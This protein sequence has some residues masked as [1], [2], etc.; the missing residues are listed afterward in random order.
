MAIERCEHCGRKIKTI[1]GENN[2]DVSVVC[3]EAFGKADIDTL[4]MV[5][6]SVFHGRISECGVVGARSLGASWRK[7]H[8]EKTDSVVREFRE[9]AYAA[10]AVSEQAT[11]GTVYE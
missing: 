2:E 4:A 11:W 1:M 7:Y 9:A 3:M 8:P 10:A 6:Y 5:I